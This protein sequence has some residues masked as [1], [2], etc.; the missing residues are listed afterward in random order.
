[1]GT[2]A[3]GGSRLG[4][5]A[6]WI[7]R[8][9]DDPIDRVILSGLRAE[10]VDL[11]TVR[12]DD[13]QA[14]LRRLAD[15]TKV[16]YYRRGLAARACPSTT[17]MKPGQRLCLCVSSGRWCTE[18]EN[19]G[20][21]LFGVRNGGLVGRFG[22]VVALEWSASVAFGRVLDRCRPGSGRTGGPG[23]RTH[24][25][26]AANDRIAVWLG[27]GTPSR[28]ATLSNSRARC[29][30]IARDPRFTT[31]RLCYILCAPTGLP[32]ASCDHAT[33]T[34]KKFLF[35]VPGSK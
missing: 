24:R 22:F 10:N 33:R 12:V 6:A 1:M 9:G 13:V 28:S 16:T 31:I 27:D 19:T 20:G 3:I 2:V 17:S 18:L 32:A 4:H 35:S 29:L 14:G 30:T 5:R 8:V 23:C 21:S 25:L 26:P 11:S 15:R 34:R 7:G